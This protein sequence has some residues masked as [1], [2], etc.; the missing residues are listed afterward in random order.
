MK[1][2]AVLLVLLT[3]LGA[4][5]QRNEGH[6]MGKGPSRDMTPEQMATL[7]TKRLILALDLTQTQQDQVM[8]LNLE[9]A[10]H[11]KA[12][13]EEMKAKKE[14]G[15]WKNPT[16]EQRFEMENARLDRQIVHQQRMKQVLT[17]DQYN[18]WKKMRLHKSVHGKKKMQESERRG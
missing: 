12:H 16:P 14:S 7:Q 18:T 3:T 8:E 1:R 2:L 13:W 4:L 11:R 9:E 15:A 5:G 10:E 17:E 6:R